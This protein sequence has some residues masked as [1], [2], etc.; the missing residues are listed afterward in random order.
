MNQGIARTEAHRLG[1]VGLCFFGTTNIDL[2]KSDSRIGVSKVSIER[3]RMFTLGDPRSGASGE[4][5]DIP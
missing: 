1:D 3:Q 4:Y 2:A 5:L